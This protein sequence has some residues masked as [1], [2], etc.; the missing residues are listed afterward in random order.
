MNT[1]NDIETIMDIELLVNSFY[2]KLQTNPVIGY[3]FMDMVHLDKKMYLREMANFWENT[4]FYTG[5]YAGNPILFHKN[6]NKIFNLTTGHFIE[7]NT[8]FNA[9]VDELF[10]G[11]KASLAKQRAIGISS[12]VQT[13]IGET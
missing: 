4:L 7:W 6:L 11:E 5:S 12:V 2:Q 1:R 9:T 13:E 8:L 10:S 3:I